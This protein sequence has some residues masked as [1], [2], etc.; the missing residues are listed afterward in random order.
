M[1]EDDGTH[2][3]VIAPEEFG[4]YPE[5]KLISLS[6]YADGVLADDKGN[7]IDI[8]ATVSEEALNTFGEYEDD[9]VHVRNTKLQ[10]DYEILL[11]P[12]CFSE[13]HKRRS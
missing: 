1:V 5:F 10:T 2:I 3:K 6:Y 4:D 11:D 9:S 8:E 12:R 13:V 7:K